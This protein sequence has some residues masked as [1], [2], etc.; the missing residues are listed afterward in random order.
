MFKEIL[1]SFRIFP[2]QISRITVIHLVFMERSYF[3]LV[4][5]LPFLFL[6][7]IYLLLKFNA[8]RSWVSERFRI[9][10]VIRSIKGWGAEPLCSG[11]VGSKLKTIFVIFPFSWASCWKFR[12]TKIGVFSIFRSLCLSHKGTPSILRLIDAA[13]SWVLPL[14]FMIF[15]EELRIKYSW[16]AFFRSIIVS[17]ALFVLIERLVGLLFR[18]H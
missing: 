4:R 12:L 17:K 18:E 5:I 13:W 8:D 2:K 9:L 11:S 16:A 10:F 3:D 15:V 1:I 6:V 7:R 14:G